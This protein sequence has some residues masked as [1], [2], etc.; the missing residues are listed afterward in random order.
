MDEP[1]RL[2]IEDGTLICEAAP[3]DS[4]AIEIAQIAAIGEYTLA[5]WPGADDYF[6]VFVE[7]SGAWHR[8]AV[9][10]GWVEV[11]SELERQLNGRVTPRLVN[12]TDTA[13]VILWPE[14][15]SGQLLFKIVGKHVEFSDELQRYLERAP[16]QRM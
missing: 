11:H 10:S 16:Q 3:A 9:E 8:V 13:S 2:T 14:E 6:E 12:C 15:L 1:A 5:V 7:R 4:W